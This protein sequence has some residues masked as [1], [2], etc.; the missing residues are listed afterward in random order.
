MIPTTTRRTTIEWLLGIRLPGPKTKNNTVNTVSY[1]V[2]YTAYSSCIAAVLKFTN[3]LRNRK[4][5]YTNK[6]YIVYDPNVRISRLRSSVG[7][8]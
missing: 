1:F 6:M 3:S 5:P 4:T 2:I 8:S 7:I